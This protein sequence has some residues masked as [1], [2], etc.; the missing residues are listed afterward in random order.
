MDDRGFESINVIP[1]ID[2]MLV[3]LTIVLVTSTFIVTGAI[4]IKL[5]QAS[6]T[7]QAVRDGV[8][9]EIAVSGEMTLNQNRLQV[10]DLEQRLAKYSKQTP[11]LIR[12]DAE[13]PLQDFVTVLDKVKGLGFKQLT[14]QTKAL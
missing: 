10:S 4:D 12:A 2:I 3:L 6:A 11:V 8:I 14:L 13:L 9:L 1:F 7:P 5:P